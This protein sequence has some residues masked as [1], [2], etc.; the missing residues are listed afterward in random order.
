MEPVEPVAM[1]VSSAACTSSNFLNFDE[2][3]NEANSKGSHATQTVNDMHVLSCSPN[4][5]QDKNGPNYSLGLESRYGS[6]E[7]RTELAN[8]PCSWNLGQVYDFFVQQQ[9]FIGIQST[10]QKQWLKIFL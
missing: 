3:T 1:F 8:I 7:N 4:I 9:L 6:N 10:Y 5:I 2:I